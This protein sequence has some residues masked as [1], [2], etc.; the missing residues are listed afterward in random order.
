MSPD[1]A[2]LPF[3]CDGL[4]DK[5]RILEELHTRRQ[6]KIRKCTSFSGTRNLFLLLSEVTLL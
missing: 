3:L 2:R 6:I 5:I 4:N 1:R